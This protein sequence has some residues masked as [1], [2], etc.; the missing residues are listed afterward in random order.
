MNAARNRTGSALLMAIGLLAIIGT[1]G[2]AF[3]AISHLD[4]KQNRALARAAPITM[5]SVAREVL[6]R[7]LNDRAD[8][9]HIGASG[10]YSAAGNVNQTIDYAHEDVDVILASTMPFV[11]NMGTLTWGHLSNMEGFPLGDVSGVPVT[12][13]D[14]VDTDGWAEPAVPL[15]LEVG[16][17]AMEPWEVASDCDVVRIG[18]K[19]P[20]LIMSGGIDKRVLAQDKEA[21]D[22]H[23]E[24]IVPAMV[25][26][27]GYTPTC[28]H[29][30]PD[31][32]SLENYLHYRKRI[33]ESDH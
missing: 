18:R 21:I 17:D 13:G 4:R 11:D 33:C 9:L 2:I 7:I 3:A 30:V 8:D 27:G 25:E 22:R 5:D 1:L 10:P 23:L 28:D 19:W 15:Y 32:V 14:L 16:M 31:D 24:H 29:G 6:V 20:D 26:R 12:D